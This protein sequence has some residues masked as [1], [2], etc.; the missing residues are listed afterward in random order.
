KNLHIGKIL[1]KLKEHRKDKWEGNITVNQ[2]IDKAIT[3]KRNN[4][5]VLENKD[6]KFLEENLR[7]LRQSKKEKGKKTSSTSVLEEI[8]KNIYGLE[9]VKRSMMNAINAI[10]INK[11]REKLGLK[12]TDIN[13][14]FAFYGAPGVGKTEIAKYFGK[15]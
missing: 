2:G 5:R 12:T 1:K 14:I 15:L 7:E 9:N 11:A 4:S 3:L 6:F 8:D 13:N 10:E